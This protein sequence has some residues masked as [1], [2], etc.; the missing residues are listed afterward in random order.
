MN[1]TQYNGIIYG[2]VE[3]ESN[4]QGLELLRK[5][6]DNMG[7]ALPHGDCAA[8]LTTLRTNNYMGWRRCSITEAK[9]YVEN[10]TA[11]IAV[12]ANN[13][14]IISA[15]TNSNSTDSGI[16]MTANEVT[17]ALE[18]VGMEFYTYNYAKMDEE[19]YLAEEPASVMS[20]RSA[21]TRSVDDNNYTCTTA[22]TISL[23]T[24]YEG[25]IICPC[26]ERWYEFTANA[27]GATSYNIYST[28]STDVFCALYNSK[29]QSI[30]YDDDSGN[31]FN[32]SINC[33]LEYGEMYYIRI[34]GY[35]VNTGNYRF[36]VTANVPESYM[37]VS[38]VEVCPVTKSIEVGYDAKLTAIVYPSNATDKSLIWS[39]SNTSVACVGDD[40]RILAMAPGKA[41]ITATALNGK[42]DS[43]EVTVKG[44]VVI[45]KDPENEFFN[46]II[47][48]TSGKTWYCINEDVLY[49]N[50]DTNSLHDN[51]LME[52]CMKNL[53]VNTNY[54]DKFGT[55]TEEE[56]KLIYAIDPHGFAYYV[57]NY[58]RRG[59]ES[60]SLESIIKYKDY[61]FEMLFKR[62][63]KYYE[64][65]LSGKWHETINIDERFQ[66]IVS[67]SELIFGMHPIYDE[68]TILEIIGF[69]VDIFAIACGKVPSLKTV[70]KFFSFCFTVTEAVVMEDYLAILNKTGENFVDDVDDS[71]FG[72]TDVDWANNILDVCT[73]ITDIAGILCSTID[74][75][76]YYKE[77]IYH[78]TSSNDYNIYIELK[79]KTTYQMQDIYDAINLL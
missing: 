47:F 36:I 42:S 68:V 9:E 41:I 77:I 2:T 65:D 37:P 19:I 52:R 24:W 67:E 44:K 45:K 57:H 71:F 70:G 32:F 8:I 4:L 25:C 74:K 59:R 56:K 21:A 78:C 6:C 5:I 28:G 15:D 66:S 64:R 46:N 79:N 40:G 62:K 69:V 55:Y 60:D 49:R 76:T 11:T 14:A 20:L 53:L 26:E 18:V 51:E 22:K 33:N 48:E 3:Q 27:S 73:V 7:V 30:T 63:P 38:S 12:S 72:K 43:C 61:I 29:G 50:I 16:I 10:G 23:N 39:S 13:V 17:P 75:P 54:N 31:C 35:G 58:A 1:K 34:M